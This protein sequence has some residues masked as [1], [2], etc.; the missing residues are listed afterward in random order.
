[1][2]DSSWKVKKRRD[3]RQNTPPTYL[4]LVRQKSYERKDGLFEVTLPSEHQ[5]TRENSRLLVKTACLPRV[6][7]Y[8]E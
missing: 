8:A 1:S 7:G 5:R 4:L 2:K 3:F 6:A